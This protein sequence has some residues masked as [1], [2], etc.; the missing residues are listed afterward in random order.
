MNETRESAKDFARDLGRVAA[1]WAL[2]SPARLAI[3]V[4]GIFLLIAVLAVFTRA[5]A[6]AKP[7]T[8]ATHTWTAPSI[9]PAGSPTGTPLAAGPQANITQ[10]G[11]SPTA[12]PT[13]V[14]ADPKILDAAYGFAHSWT[15]HPA[16]ISTTTWL[17]GLTPYTTPGLLAQLKAADPT[18][19][20]VDSVTGPPRLG[21]TA[22]GQAQVVV[23]GDPYPV[24]L[25]VVHSP[26][27]WLVDSVNVTG[28]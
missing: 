25:I 11:P 8:A 22:D 26:G 2:R 23:P 7:H 6:P 3:S 18:M 21:V 1:N 16:G 10:P 5:P 13:Q 17:Y 15:Y 19:V 20:P 28:V 24:D 12:T 14:K 27:G 4:L 9:S